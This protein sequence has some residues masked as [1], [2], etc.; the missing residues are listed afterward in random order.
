MSLAIGLIG[1]IRLVTSFMRNDRVAWLRFW[2]FTIPVMPPLICC[3]EGG[4][5]RPRTYE[6][7]G[8][9]PDWN[10]MGYS[11]GRECGAF[12]YAIVNV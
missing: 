9:Y 1:G 12:N 6:T 7:T 11:R 4:L 3:D 2:G 5:T 10:F 8:D